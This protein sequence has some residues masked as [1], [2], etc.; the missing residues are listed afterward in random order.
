MELSS[1]RI[2]SRIILLSAFQGRCYFC[3]EYRP[4][5]H[6]ILARQIRQVFRCDSVE[7][8]S[9]LV[10]AAGGIIGEGIIKSLRLANKKRQG[11]AAAA[12]KILAADSDARAAGLYRA[13]EGFLVPKASAPD[14]IEGLVK[15]ARNAGA[16]GIFVGADEELAVVG[17][18]ADRIKSE[19]GAVVI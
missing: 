8:E 18:A 13:D 1:S 19:S 2:H 10:T 7:K 9:V 6:I 16:R 17:S 12:Y 5:A 14:Y 15:V 11:S 3:C 4:V